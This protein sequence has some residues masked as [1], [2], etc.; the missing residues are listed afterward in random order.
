MSIFSKHWWHH[1]IK[2][3]KAV[4]DIFGVTGKLDKEEKSLGQSA[5]R[6]YDH[7]ADQYEDGQKDDQSDSQKALGVLAGSLTAASNAE[8]DGDGDEE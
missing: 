6:S 5:K 2:K 7:G 3:W 1:H 8:S 4:G